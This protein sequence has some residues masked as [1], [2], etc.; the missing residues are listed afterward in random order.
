[1]DTYDFIR[2]EQRGICT[3]TDR[4]ETKRKMIHNPKA[5]NIAEACTGGITAIVCYLADWTDLIQMVGIW[6]GT[7]LTLLGLYGWIKR[8][9]F[10]KDQ[11]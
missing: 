10:D 4:K 2:D 6:A 9:L 1:M 5:Q 8:E 7:L 3:K 11:K